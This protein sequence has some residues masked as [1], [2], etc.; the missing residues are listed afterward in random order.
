MLLPSIVK[1]LC[2]RGF[3]NISLFII[4]N[5]ELKEMLEFEISRLNLQKII[6]LFG[7]ITQEELINVLDNS[8]VFLLPGIYSEEDGRA[9]CQGLVIQE[10]QAME[11]PVI[12][13]D[14]GGM[15]Y[16]MIPNITGFVVKENDISGF[17]DCIEA[18]IK[19]PSKAVKMGKE[20]RKFVAENYSS[21]YL[22]DKLVSIYLN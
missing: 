14:V 7:S 12:I 16:G 4:G 21:T 18:L 9:E 13:S 20:G 15:K 2:N 1:E 8:D 3:K 22:V 10:A 6:E 19:D 11:L 17:A 5:G